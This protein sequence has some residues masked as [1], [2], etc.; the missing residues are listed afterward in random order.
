ML[1]QP[2]PCGSGKL[3]AA[4]DEAE[5]ARCVECGGGYHHTSNRALRCPACRPAHN[6]AVGR[7]RKARWT[8]ERRRRRLLER[9]AREA[10]LFADSDAREGVTK[11]P[12]Q[13]VLTLL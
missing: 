3:R 1:D 4:C 11:S 2:C 12:A 7:A 8:A 9:D 10:Q 6:L 5:L 13:E